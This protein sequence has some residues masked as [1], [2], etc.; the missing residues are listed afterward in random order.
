[1]LNARADNRVLGK[2][3]AIE[4]FRQIRKQVAPESAPRL[5]EN[6]RQETISAPIVHYS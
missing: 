3:K 2:Y 4:T 6:A 5:Q 1:M